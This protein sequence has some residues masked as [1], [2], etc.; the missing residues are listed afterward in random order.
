MITLALVI[1]FIVVVNSVLV[2]S[3][4]F[5]GDSSRL[6]N[7]FCKMYAI[8][9]CILAVFMAFNMSRQNQ[10]IREKEM[11]EQMINRSFRKK[12]LISS[13]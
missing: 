8:V 11:M 5:S 9:C 4:M 2:D 7:V 10:I 1:L 6:Q 12:L 13:I 3:T